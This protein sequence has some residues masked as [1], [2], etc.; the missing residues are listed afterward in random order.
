[1]KTLNIITFIFLRNLPVV[2]LLAFSGS[3]FGGTL[4]PLVDDFSDAR[5]N[6]LGIPRQFLN[7]TTSGGSTTTEQS[8]SEGVLAVKG[9]IVPPRGQP[10]WASS[11][12]L[13]DPH[14]L[15]TDASAFEGIRLLVKVEKGNI[16]ISANSAEVTNFDYHAA[17]VMATSDGKFHE[18][19]I[20]FA[21]MKRAWSEQ[22]PL[23][24][25][26]I[27]SLSIVAF[28]LQKGVFEF[29]VDEVSFY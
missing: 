8:A 16:S 3:S 18:V 7:D 2:A 24:P 27:S 1:M 10:G 5:N 14:G 13:L 19:K 21:S 26:T 20:P 22:T 12:L 11:V 6:S 28:D 17:P 4:S 15:P 9:E 23:N 29:E 25:K